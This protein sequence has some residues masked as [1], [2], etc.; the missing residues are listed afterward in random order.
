[1][2][3][4][5]ISCVVAAVC[6]YATAALADNQ[7]PPD[8]VGDPLSYEAHWDF[9]SQPNFGTGL[10]PDSEDATGGSGNETLYDGF[11]THIDLSGDWS[12]DQNSS[13]YP[14]GNGSMGVNVVNWVDDEPEKR[15]RVQVYWTG[16]IAPT[17]DAVLGYDNGVQHP[18]V[19]VDDLTQPGIL[20]EDWVI[21]PNPDWEQIVIS[22]PG[23]TGIGQIDVHTISLP[24]PASIAILAVGSL[25]LLR[26]RRRF[27]IPKRM[28]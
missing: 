12:W 25:A 15:L 16:L 19:P 18:G 9:N 26:R 11:S 8:Y 4:R 13:I 7:F 10:P 22:V 6:V 14:N 1:M 27:E 3:T 21:Y 17:I 24:E 23:G 20:V 2:V 28:A 5:V